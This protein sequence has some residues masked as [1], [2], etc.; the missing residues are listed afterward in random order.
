MF[1]LKDFECH[2]PECPMRIEEHLVDKV[3]EAAGIECPKCGQMMICSP[4][5]RARY[6]KHGSWA[7]WRM[8]EHWDQPGE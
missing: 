8:A 5:S 4:L 2:N 3:E 1:K 6:G 7:L